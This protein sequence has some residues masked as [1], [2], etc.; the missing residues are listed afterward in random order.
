VV[1]ALDLLVFQ[2]HPWPGGPVPF[3]SLAAAAPWLHQERTG[4]AKIGVEM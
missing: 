3:G 2:T 4:R 1:S